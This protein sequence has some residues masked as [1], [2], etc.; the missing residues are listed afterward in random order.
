MKTANTINAELTPMALCWVVVYPSGYIGG[1]SIL[2]P[3]YFKRTE[4]C[5]YI[6]EHQKQRKKKDIDTRTG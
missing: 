2:T 1:A 3:L 4:Q 6:K 5:R